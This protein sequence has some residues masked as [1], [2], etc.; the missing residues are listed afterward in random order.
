M[1]SDE[2]VKQAYWNNVPLNLPRTP[3]D[4]IIGSQQFLNYSRPFAAFHVISYFPFK[5]PDIELPPTLVE[6]ILSAMTTADYE[7]KDWIHVKSSL[8]YHLQQLLKY[9]TTSGKIPEIKLAQLEFYF[10]PAISRNVEPSKNLYNILGKEPVFFSDLIK[11]IYRPK[12]FIKKERKPGAKDEELQQ[13]ARRAAELL[14]SWDKLPG[15]KTDGSLDRDV[16]IK[17]VDKVHKLCSESD[18]KVKKLE[19]TIKQQG[20]EIEQLK[21]AQTLKEPEDDLARE[22]RV[23]R[24][25]CTKVKVIDN[26]ASMYFCGMM[27]VAFF[28]ENPEPQSR[29]DLQLLLQ[30]TGF[31]A[32]LVEYYTPE[33]EKVFSITGS[34]SSFATKR[35]H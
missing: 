17:W 3:A 12:Q 31:E 19:E 5:N 13:R 25:V 10:W 9:L 1:S 14:D 20:R 8:S 29:L 27:G 26:T 33:G 2:K 22:L 24:K 18:R 35:Y 16:L 34:L 15:L 6:S 28:L 7:S 32:G 23:R 4:N 11:M 30:K 21:T